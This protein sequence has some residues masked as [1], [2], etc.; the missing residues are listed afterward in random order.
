[1]AEA[2]AGQ[3]SDHLGK[4]ICG[5]EQPREKRF[6]VAQWSCGSFYFFEDG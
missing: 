5:W 4:S 3:A 2:G 1:M 6:F